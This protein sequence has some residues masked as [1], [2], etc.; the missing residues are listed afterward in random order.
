MFLARPTMGPSCTEFSTLDAG[1]LIIV[2]K[3]RLIMFSLN[4]LDYS[5]SVLLLSTFFFLGG[6][7]VLLFGFCCGTPPSWFKVMV[8]WWW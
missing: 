8:G 3:E 4:M 2:Q 1:I 7:V 5:M 6:Q